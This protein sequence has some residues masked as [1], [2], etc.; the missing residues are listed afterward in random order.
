MARARQRPHQKNAKLSRK[1]RLKSD[2]TGASPGPNQKQAKR[3]HEARLKSDMAGASPGPNQVLCGKV[4]GEHMCSM[5][6]VA[7]PE[8]TRAT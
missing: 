5:Q 7:A 8:A 1:V 2:M 3:S 4:E 6:K